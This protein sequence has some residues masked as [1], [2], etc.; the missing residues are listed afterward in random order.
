MY[1]FNLIPARKMTASELAQHTA[2]KTTDSP[3]LSNLT[4]KTDELK[5]KN[6][7]E[8]ESAGQFFYDS[9]HIKKMNSIN[10]RAMNEKR[11]RT[12]ERQNKELEPCWFC[13][14]GTKVERHYIV[15]VG[16]KVIIFSYPSK[17]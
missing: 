6:G 11:K 15:S 2:S 16:D 14:G 7:D 3:Y 17:I 9:E 5:R 10:E 12:E 4:I 8:D 13:L 1:A